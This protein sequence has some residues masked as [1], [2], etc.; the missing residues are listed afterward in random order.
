MVQ[1]QDAGLDKEQRQRIHD[2]EGIKVPECWKP[3]ARKINV[4][5][6]LSESPSVNP[7]KL[8]GSGNRFLPCS[9]SHERDVQTYQRDRHENSKHHQIIVY[10]DM[11]YTSDAT[12]QSGVWLV[13]TAR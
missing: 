10:T 1:G 4:L 11:M 12:V 2:L 8:H 7:S 3:H 9:P 13:G 6:V 5:L